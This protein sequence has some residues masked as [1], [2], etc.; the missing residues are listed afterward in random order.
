[1]LAVHSLN[2]SFLCN[3][4]IIWFFTGFRNGN[5]YTWVCDF[6]K[7]VNNWHRQYQASFGYNHS[8]CRPTTRSGQI[9]VDSLYICRNVNNC[10]GSIGYWPD[11]LS[12]WPYKTTFTN[13]GQYWSLLWIIRL[14]FLIFNEEI[15]S[16]E[17]ERERKHFFTIKL[18]EKNSVGSNVLQGLWFD[19]L[20]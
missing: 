5:Y 17:R 9:C 16:R 11:C 12:R 4:L 15:K 19:G 6:I 14:K 3:H 8:G 20:Q 2:F 10:C 18:E 1:M 13:H 7:S